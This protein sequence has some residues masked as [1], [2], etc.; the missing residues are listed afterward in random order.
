MLLFLLLF[1]DESMPRDFIKEYMKFLINLCISSIHFLTFWSS[2]FLHV[3]LTFA[4]CVKN[5]PFS[6]FILQDPQQHLL[7]HYR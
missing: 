7:A 6:K 1:K 3:L 4:P 5:K 2:W